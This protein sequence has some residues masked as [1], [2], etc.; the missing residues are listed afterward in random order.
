MERWAEQV[1][2][3]DLRVGKVGRSMSILRHVVGV[4]F[5]ILGVVG[6]FLPVLQGV[7]FLLIGLALLFPR[8]RYLQELLQKARA[9]YPE[10]AARLDA[11]KEKMRGLFQRADGAG[12]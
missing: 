3:N 9:R 2:A 1:L 6:L 4:F 8:N 5:L 10:Q 11:W 7:L 12:K